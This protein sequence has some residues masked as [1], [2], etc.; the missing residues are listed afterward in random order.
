MLPP[1]AMR[2][3]LHLLSRLFRYGHAFS[4]SSR[5]QK[6]ENEKEKEK[7]KKREKL[8]SMPGSVS[9]PLARASARYARQTKL[10]LSASVILTSLPAMRAW[11]PLAEERG[12]ASCA[13]VS[14][15][16]R[17]CAGKT[18]GSRLFSFLFFGCFGGNEHGIKERKARAKGKRGE[19]ER[20]ERWERTREVRAKERKARAKEKE[21]G[22]N[23]L[24]PP[25]VF[26]SWASP[27]CF[28]PR[29]PALSP[30]LFLSF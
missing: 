18:L 13:T 10:I 28:F 11:S 14:R 8:A 23:P 22:E 26:L 3:P 21:R 6:K 17:W 29:A 12:K 15:S 2:S 20:E 16:F 4:S 9:S 7:R 24:P 19:S 30:S 25:A 27:T 1:P 5:E